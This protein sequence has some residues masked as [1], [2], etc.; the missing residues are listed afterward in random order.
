MK[1]YFY[2]SIDAVFS[3]TVHIIFGQKNFTRYRNFFDISDTFDFEDNSVRAKAGK[4]HYRD[5]IQYAIAFQDQFPADYIITHEL[6]HIVDNIRK[7]YSIDD[8]EFNAYLIQYLFQ[9]VSA[10]KKQRAKEKQRSY[11]E[12]KH[13]RTSRDGFTRSKRISGTSS[14][15]KA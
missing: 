13:K 1:R 9:Q 12:A 6:M 8:S 10:L 3:K 5:E 2:H 14:D 11:F 15:S 7:R 4:F